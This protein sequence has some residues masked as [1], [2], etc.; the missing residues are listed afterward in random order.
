MRLLGAVKAA[1]CCCYWQG[2]MMR[3]IGARRV[4]PLETMD[5]LGIGWGVHELYPNPITQQAFQSAV[6]RLQGLE[7]TSMTYEIGA[8][9]VSCD[10]EVLD[11]ERGGTARLSLRLFVH[12]IEWLEL[13]G[14]PTAQDL[15]RFFDLLAADEHAIRDGGGIAAALAAR[16]VWSISVTQR[17]LLAE[18]LE[19]PWEERAGDHDTDTGDGGTRAAKLARMIAGGATAQAVADS[20]QEEAGGDAQRMAESF[21][22]AYRV[23]Y[24]GAEAGGPSTESVPELLAAYRQAPKSRPPIDTFAE[25][26]FL[27]PVEAQAEIL[28]DFLTNR[29]EGLHS[30][31]LDQFAG[32]ELAE[33][34][35]HLSEEMFAELIGYARDVVDSE[36]G[37]ADELLPLVSAAK[38][39]KV[40][41]LGAADRIREMIEGIGGLGGA[42]GGLAGKLRRET[43]DADALGIHVL[44]V[45]MEVEERPDAF[46]RFVESWCRGI[47]QSVQIGDLERALVLLGVG[48]AD[49]ELSPQKQ[50]V[51]AAGLV[52]LLRSDYAVFS[53]AAQNPEKRELVGA[54][55]A[56]F[57]EPAAAHLMDRL[58]A[59][60]DSAIRRVLI[61]LLVIVG[62]HHSRPIIRFFADP[63][64]FVV[65][66][67]V[68]IAGKV[69]GTEWVPHLEPLLAHSDHRVVVEAMR[70]LAP[71][72]PDIA[73]PGLVR[74]LANPHD[75]IRETAFLLLK[76]SA[77]PARQE[78]LAAALTDR[79][80]DGARSEIAEL[81][82]DIGTPEA[83]G[84]LE[85]LASK[86]FVISPIR[87]DA[88]RAAREVLRSAA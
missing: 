35:P 3:D 31:L 29:T 30:L 69:G 38:D 18:A 9:T 15:A 56:G 8:G 65:R 81:L 21:C 78:A 77:S 67:A 20:L 62:G 52:E 32:L 10:G 7:G 63:R 12:E 54:L 49:V 37:S 40:A 19:R 76:D 48:T 1:Y 73:L 16:D 2:F 4:D 46:A 34:A 27:I 71:L 68:T 75:R 47:S 72:A 25:T 74:N 85:Q 44:R 51:V 17:G 26:F 83:L 22:D 55:L 64:W 14:P 53:D 36:T 86:S 88:R 70:A 87:R 58:S 60:E 13:I 84:V 5:A 82:F 79:S 33:L 39:V 42:S 50:R 66:N 24:P 45:L 80:M 61:G 57:G 59:E 11:L 43:A 6:A 28:S 41:R 23:V